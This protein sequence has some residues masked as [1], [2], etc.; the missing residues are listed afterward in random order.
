MVLDL[1]WRIKLAD[2]TRLKSLSLTRELQMPDDSVEVFDEDGMPGDREAFRP[3]LVAV[4]ELL[5]GVSEFIVTCG[6]TMFF[7]ERVDDQRE[8]EDGGWF[9]T[10]ISLVLSQIPA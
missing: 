2:F 9:V 8:V 10:T 4:Q 3:L 1:L 7:A 5:P 6:R